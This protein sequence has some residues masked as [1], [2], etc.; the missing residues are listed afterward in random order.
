MAND[1]P[2]LRELCLVIDDREHKVFPHL[3]VEGQTIMYT[4]KRIQV[5]DFAIINKTT[6][7][8]YTIF[9]RKT[10]EDYAASF[11]DGRYL[12]KEKLI[13]LRK[14]CGCQI[15]FII[16][17]PLT[18]RPNATFGRIPYK[19]IQRSIFHMQQVDGIIVHYTTSPEHSAKYLVSYL[20]SITTII[21][22]V[23]QSS[24]NSTIEL[25]EGG[26]TTPTIT[27]A[28]VSTNLTDELTTETIPQEL[29]DKTPTSD[30]D[31]LRA[32]WS[33]FKGINVILADVF[34]VKISIADVI[35]GRV[36]PDQLD[37]FKSA[38]GR[39]I[40]KNVSKSLKDAID[41]KDV[42]VALRLLSAIPGIGRQTA[43]TILENRTL[44]QL[45]SYET[46]AISIISVGKNN[47]KLGNSAAM[48]IKKYFN[49][50]LDGD[51]NQIAVCPK[52]VPK[53]STNTVT[54]NGNVLGSVPTSMPTL[55]PLQ[56]QPSV[57]SQVELSP[58]LLAQMDNIDWSTF[59][60]QT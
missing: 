4:K 10:F 14:K 54:S 38:G 53:V 26:T 13:D 33:C 36:T 15:I 9:E 20:E 60:H 3:V 29:L 52:E 34:I 40:S 5:G 48:N 2:T 11:K 41:I 47:R 43:I 27:P 8:I 22:S 32:L 42:S 37:D 39:S 28:V 57:I 35:C 6:N 7:Q 30:V 24:A 59:T 50:K 12:N 17:G 21:K 18:P 56:T 45:L 55:M 46:G 19:H 25:F 51:A 49:L 44:K 16:E 58:E 31:I 1:Y 23:L